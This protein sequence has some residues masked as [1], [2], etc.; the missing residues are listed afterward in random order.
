MQKSSE[1]QSRLGYE[2]KRQVL[3]QQALTH[4]SFSQD[5]NERLEFLGDSILNLSI[6]EALYLRFPTAREGDLSRL[7][8]SLVKG[9][10]LADLARDFSLGEYLRLGEGEQKS[11]G[12][13]RA[14]ILADVV[15]AIIG[16]IY[17]DADFNTAKGII[18]DWFAARLTQLSLTC[19]EKDPKTQLQELLQ[20]RKQ[21]LPLYEVVKV[22]GESHAQVFTVSCK[23]ADLSSVTL[24]SAASRRAAE[25]EAAD[26]M[27]QILRP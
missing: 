19:D 11:G 2:F 7:R 14:S 26:K 3:L 18:L 15:E 21:P 4:R 13:Q 5:H 27:L 25:K 17:L 12:A 23:V 16:A 22:D 1:L 8:A 20:G 9:D 10:T 24:G 6:A